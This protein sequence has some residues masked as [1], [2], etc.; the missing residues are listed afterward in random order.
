MKKKG[1]LVATALVM[2]AAQGCYRE[3][4]FFKAYNKAP[5]FAVEKGSSILNTLVD[6]CKVGSAKMLTYTLK[7]EGKSCAISV[8]DNLNGNVVI[9]QREGI[10]DTLRSLSQPY[11][12]GTGRGEV[13]F[14]GKSKG[15]FH[16]ILSVED[17]YGK[18][19][20]FEY[21]MTVV[22]NQ[23]PVC[24]LEVRSSPEH[25]PYE[26]V[27]DIS[28]SYDRD[29]QLGGKIVTYDYRIGGYYSFTTDN[30]QYTILNHIFPT[31]GKYVV[32]C[33]VKDDSGAWSDF[34]SKE[35]EIK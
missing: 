19:T 28:K 4:D 20:P 27:V 11:S 31:V 10:Y 33:R 2:V 25:S 24:V 5:V 6:S 3:D 12:T 22:E 13:G 29:A 32:K 21:T 17:V 7:D 1:I 15:V 30:P 35:V 34:T 8:D 26:Y 18:K 14:I 16:G 9:K 23:A